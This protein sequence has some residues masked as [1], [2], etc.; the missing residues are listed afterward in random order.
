MKQSYFKKMVDAEVA[1]RMNESRPVHTQM[2]LDAAMLAANEV[3]KMGPTYA[4][5]FAA[6][7]SQALMEIAEMTVSDTR[8]LEYTK[9]KLD[10]RL[11]K[12][13]GEKFQPW[14]ERYSW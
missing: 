6:A 10:A 5:S 14:D 9:D 3:L 1:R 13:V 11:Q 12:I 2:C 4:E 8:D 7:F